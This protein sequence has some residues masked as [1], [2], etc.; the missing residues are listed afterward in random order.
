MVAGQKKDNANLP[1]VLTEDNKANLPEDP[2]EDNKANLPE[3][4]VATS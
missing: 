4:P 3:D 1:E 2:T